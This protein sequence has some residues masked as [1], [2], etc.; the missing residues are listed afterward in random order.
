MLEEGFNSIRDVRGELARG[1]RF[2]DT[3]MVAVRKLHD[4]KSTLPVDWFLQFEAANKW[5]SV[6]LMSC[7]S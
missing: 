5:V 2:W 6:T 3:V 4:E 7:G 1:V